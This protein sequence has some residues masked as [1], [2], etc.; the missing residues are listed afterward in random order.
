MQNRIGFSAGAALTLLC[1]IGAGCQSYHAK[2]PDLEAHHVEWLD[3]SADDERISAYAQ[4][5]TDAGALQTSFDPSDGIS[6]AEAEVIA[7]VFNAEL[8]VGRAEAGVA[9]ATEDNAGLWQDPTLGVDVMRVLANVE[10]Q[11]MSMANVGFTIPISGRLGK[12]KEL[13]SAEH[14]AALERVVEMEWD[15][16]IALR[17]AWVTWS[18]ANEQVDVTNNYLE[19]LSSLISI[20]DGMLSVGELNRLESR[21]FHIERLTGEQEL[22]SLEGMREQAA[23]EIRRLMGFAP[24]ANVALQPAIRVSDEV[25]GSLAVEA[26]IM[27]RNTTL[28]KLHAEYESA[29]R[30]LELEIRKQYPDINLGAGHEYDDGNNRVG[31]GVSFPIPIFN[32]NRLAIAQ[33]RAKREKALAELET[34]LESVL[35]ELADANVQHDTAAARRTLVEK[36]IVPLVDA[37][38]SDARE[39]ARLGEVDTWLLLETLRKRFEVKMQLITFV[40]DESDAV[41]LRDH[42]IGPKSV[43]MTAPGE[44]K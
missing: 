24:H 17:K 6:L 22:A 40:Q 28:R 43:V 5:L 32:G 11:W 12:E 19:E 38:F 33:A 8:R 26:V 15:T 9:A 14:R 16:V 27:E 25:Q 13:A 35:T 23:I 29:E 42:V 31:V 18:A 44:V 41:I 30:A 34:A 20:V 1:A 2:P 7:L 39:V 36:Q 3:R 4:R 10:H 21:L 37:Q